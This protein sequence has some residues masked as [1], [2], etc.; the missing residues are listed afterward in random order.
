MY[1]LKAVK[2]EELTKKYKLEV[3]PYREMDSNFFL[4]CRGIFVLKDS[5]AMH[6]Y[7]YLCNCYN[8]ATEKVFPSYDTIQ[9]ATGLNR[10]TVSNK[11]KILQK[12]KLIKINKRKVGTGFN[13]Y[14]L[15]NYIKSVIEKSKINENLEIEEIIDM[16]NCLADLKLDTSIQN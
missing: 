7:L 4:V 14:Y 3:A 8:R 5:K 12:L 9:R 15:I 6:L 16:D 10:N 13:N 1:N 11:L 2:F